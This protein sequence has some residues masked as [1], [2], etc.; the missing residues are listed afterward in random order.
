MLIASRGRPASFYLL[1]FEFRTFP[2]P[3][4]CFFRTLL[5]VHTRGALLRVLRT[6]D[7][8]RH[9]LYSHGVLPRVRGGRSWPLR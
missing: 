1:I 6:R 7:V 9:V 5:S 8:P 4:L 3:F 2:M